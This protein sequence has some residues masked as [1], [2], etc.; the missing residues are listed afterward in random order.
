MGF[1]TFRISG[2]RKRG[3]A[4]SDGLTTSVAPPLAAGD[5]QRAQS[6]AS[7]K[8]T[9]PSNNEGWCGTK[10]LSWIFQ[11]MNELPV[12]DRNP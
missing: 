8:L 7:T 1:Q 11:E 3:R 12:G 2:T 9:R 6:E 10:R 4:L 5:D